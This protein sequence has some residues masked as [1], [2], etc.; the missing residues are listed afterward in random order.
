[1]VTL[2]SGPGTRLC[3]TSGGTLAHHFARV[4]GGLDDDVGADQKLL[5]GLQELL[6]LVADVEL[7]IVIEGEMDPATKRFLVVR[8]VVWV[9]K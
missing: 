8:A 9:D 6:A 7:L 4:V 2:K 5:V 3:T 1:M